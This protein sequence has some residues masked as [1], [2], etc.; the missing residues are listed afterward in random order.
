M[1]VLLLYFS[2][3]RDLWC[4]DYK[5]DLGYEA[6]PYHTF[7]INEENRQTSLERFNVNTEECIAHCENVGCLSFTHINSTGR[8][9]VQIGHKY[10]A[11]FRKWWTKGNDSGAIS[12]QRLCVKGLW[13]WKA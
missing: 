1:L 9:S 11:E 13:N 4:K 3:V 8:C 7:M 12:Y 5:Y 10:T 6:L 2:V